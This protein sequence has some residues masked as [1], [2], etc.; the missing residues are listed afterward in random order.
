VHSAQVIPEQIGAAGAAILYQW[1]ILI[2][3][4]EQPDRKNELLRSK[5]GGGAKFFFLAKKLKKNCNC[6]IS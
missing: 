6:A 4:P 2:F 1:Y 5:R 3:K